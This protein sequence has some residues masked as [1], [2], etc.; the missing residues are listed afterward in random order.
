MKSSNFHRL[1]GIDW[2][3]AKDPRRGLRVAQCFQGTAVPQIVLNSDGGNWRSKEI[4][5]WLIK[6]NNRGG[7]GTRGF[8][9]P[10]PIPTVMRRHISLSTTKP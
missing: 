6:L 9:S 4:L 10:L 7:K 3:G 5:D 2:S 1:I 8:D